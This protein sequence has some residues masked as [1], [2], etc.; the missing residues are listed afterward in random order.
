MAD[1]IDVAQ[2]NGVFKKRYAKNVVYVVPEDVQLIREFGFDDSNKFGEDWNEPVSLTLENGFT[3]VAAGTTGNPDINL[4]VAS[5]TKN[6]N[7]DSPQIFLQSAINYEAASRAM[8]KG[9]AAIA[10][11]I[12]HVIRNNTQS[13]RNWQEVQTFHGQTDLGV[14]ESAVSGAGGTVT[15]T[16]ATWAPGIWAGREGLIIDILHAALSSVIDN[17]MTITAINFAT[18][19]ITFDD[20]ATTVAAGHRLFARDCCNAGTAPTFKEPLGVQKALA[21]SGSIYGISTTAFTL[22]QAGSVAAGGVLDFD[23]STEAVA[24]VAEKG[25]TGLLRQYVNPHSFNDLIGDQAALRSYDEDGSTS[26]YRT[27][28]RAIRFY[29]GNG[30]VA[31]IPT[32]Y[33]KRGFSFVLNTRNWKRKGS[34]DF[35]FSSPFSTEAFHV[36]ESKGGAFARSFSSTTPFCRSLAQNAL[37]TGIVDSIAA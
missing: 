22:W 31:V 21:G 13:H 3:F 19:T 9:E 36:F 35:S 4:P 26:Q 7:V 33:M 32:I 17:D 28:A 18:R 2:L 34:Q 14:V 27:G 6:A 29:T 20:V 23:H 24:R 15:I 8:Q 12:E 25:G 11:A 37:I 10:R 5:S 16:K 1:T 30:E